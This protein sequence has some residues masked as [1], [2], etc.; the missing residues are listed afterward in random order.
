MV[1]S[2]R[3]VQ[4]SRSSATCSESSE[5]SR[6]LRF[7]VSSS[8][9]LS[10]SCCWKALQKRSTVEPWRS[11]SFAWILSSKLSSM[12]SRRLRYA[13]NLARVS[14]SSRIVLMRPPSR[15]LLTRLARSR[16]VFSF[17]ISTLLAE[18][19]SR[20][21]TSCS[22]SSSILASAA[23][24]SSSVCWSFCVRSSTCSLRSMLSLSSSVFLSFRSSSSSA[25]FSTVSRLSWLPSPSSPS[26]PSPSSP[27]LPSSIASRF[28]SSAS[29]F[30]ASSSFLVPRSM[31]ALAKVFFVATFDSRGY[32]GQPQ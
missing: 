20:Q 17:S 14:R 30:A 24:S 12:N 31:P 23:S 32:T 18:S 8:A 22:S 15:S 7:S 13:A 11:P 16:V 6:R 9:R 5:T 27:S 3:S 21:R 26:S 25:I 10:F 2:L 28:F 29:F 4:R 1:V 19:F